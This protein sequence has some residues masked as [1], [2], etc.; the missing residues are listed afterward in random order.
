M[1]SITTPIEICPMHTFTDVTTHS[2]AQQRNSTNDSTYRVYLS[3]RCHIC[4]SEGE[5][6]VASSCHEKHI[7]G[8]GKSCYSSSSMKQVHAI[9][10]IYSEN[11]SGG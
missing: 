7:H 2:S 5:S 6:K 8:A 1:I 4:A 9:L 10:E 11:V 3:V